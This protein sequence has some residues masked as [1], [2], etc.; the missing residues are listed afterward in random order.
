[1]LPIWITM[2]IFKHLDN[3]TLKLVKDVNKYWS[4]VV[5]CINQEEK[6]RKKLD[7][8][9]ESIEVSLFF[10]NFTIFYDVTFYFRMILD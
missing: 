4:F 9:I 10:A 1:M 6:G 3:K 2:K 5:D 7:D 8:W